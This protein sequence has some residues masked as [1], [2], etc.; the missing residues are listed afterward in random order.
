MTERSAVIGSALVF[1]VVLASCGDD[2]GAG[3]PIV[4]THGD[5][6]S[7]GVWTPGPSPAPPRA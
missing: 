3:P 2:H 5:A 4:A 7:F 1:V 6:A